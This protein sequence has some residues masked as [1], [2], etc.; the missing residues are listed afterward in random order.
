MTTT[1]TPG[2]NSR[3]SIWF[4]YDKNGRKVAYYWSSR[5]FRSIRMSVADAE[6][7]IANETADQISGHPFKP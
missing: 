5:G 4:D 2:Y 1:Q 7:F 6:M 3:I